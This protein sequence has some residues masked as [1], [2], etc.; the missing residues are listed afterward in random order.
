MKEAL[1]NIA[2]FLAVSQVMYA[3]AAKKVNKTIR[4]GVAFA[5]FVGVLLYQVNHFATT[6]PANY[7]EKLE[8]D[9]SW[10]SPITVKSNYKSIMNRMAQEGSHNDTA[11]E[12]EPENTNSTEP[13]NKNSTETKGKKKDKKMSKAKRK[14]KE[15]YDCLMFS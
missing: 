14:I 10:P 3:L 12:E 6:K 13:D 4:M 7:F 2:A 9:N 5:L 11:V 8:L 15:I 1:Y